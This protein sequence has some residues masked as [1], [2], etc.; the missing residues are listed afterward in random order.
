MEKPIY[1]SGKEFT[2]QSFGVSL[3]RLSEWDAVIKKVPTPI[4]LHSIVK[5]TI[6]FCS[7][8]EEL[9]YFMLCVGQLNALR[10]R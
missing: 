3:E 6:E 7:T 1:E 9:S 10:N 4:T 5:A 2:Y 8:P